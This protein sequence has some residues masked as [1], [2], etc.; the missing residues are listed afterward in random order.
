MNLLVTYSQLGVKASDSPELT[1]QK[2]FLAYLA[3]FMSGGGILWGSISLSYDLVWQSAIPFGYV[4][5][6]AIN[7]AIFS[8]TKEIKLVRAFQVLISLVLPFMF[9]WSL[10]SFY[11]SGF[12]MLWAVLSLIASLSFS[13]GSNALI[14]L[15]LFLTLTVV[16]VIYD[17]YFVSLKPAILPDKS[18]VFTA[19]NICTIITIVF[20]LV[21]YFV[22]QQRTTQAAL[23]EKRKEI[24]LINKSLVEARNI[25][26]KKNLELEKMKKELL[27]ITERQTEINRKL[28]EEKSEKQEVE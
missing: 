9:Q 7:M 18:L 6:S 22:G 8:A 25:S 11:A 20:F 27:E 24:E 16:S 26:E 4:L 13:N 19:V 1:L 15:G 3:L 10:G 2:S 14:W 5:L 28:M 12:I 23:I 17:P 21:A